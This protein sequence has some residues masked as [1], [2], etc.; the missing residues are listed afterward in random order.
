MTQRL[1][2]GLCS[3][4]ALASLV[5]GCMTATSPA[6]GRSFSTSVSP[7]QEAAMG[8]KEHPKILAEFGGAYQEKPELTT[9][10]SSIGQFVAATSERKD[11]TY[12]FTV[13]NTPDVNAFAVPGGYIYITRG[14]LTLAG[15]EAEVAGVLGHEIGHI[16]ARHTAERMGQ[17][18]QAQWEVMGAT[19]LGAIFGGNA[20]AQWAGS[21]MGE[22]AEVQLAQYSQQQ[23]F[24]ADSLGVRYLKRATYDP[25]AM[26]E[27]LGSLRAQSQL[28]AKLAGKDPSTVDANNMMASHPRTVDRVEKAIAEA[29]PAAPNAM[30]E[31]EVYLRK[32]DGMMFGDDPKE[33][34]IEGRKFIH[35]TLHF[36]F[37][38]P[39]GFHLV[40]TP[41]QV[42]V[43]GPKGVAMALDVA[44]PQPQGD[45]ADY[46]AAGAGYKNISFRNIQALQI[47]GMPA[48]TGI[49]RA[50]TSAGT[51]DARL[52][53]IRHPEGKVYEFLVLMSPS[54]SASYDATMLQS[55]QTFQQ[56]SA[57]EGSR[58]RPQRIHIIK[59]KQGD[60]VASLSAQ[61]VVTEDKQDWFRVLNELKPG[62]EPKAGRLVKIVTY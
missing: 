47:N 51:A 39:Q 30:L 45:L 37:M 1:L 53:L 14:L 9:Y 44:D 59:V 54:V 5:S 56:I 6:T 4:F 29:G 61:M 57:S 27:F 10:V 50:N 58:Y 18:Q 13:L 17:Q 35:P 28:E 40:N 43:G 36:S 62:E 20:G 55:V 26:A 60:T 41:D 19:L 23:E 24:E 32:I 22:H 52:V 49:T 42:Q 8:Q 31:P 11:V 15:N 7:Q 21:K 38:A 33:G 3:S 16:N 48:A 46:I 25:Q 2:I 34:V 12:T